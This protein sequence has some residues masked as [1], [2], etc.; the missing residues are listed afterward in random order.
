MLALNLF[1]QYYQ[2]TEL[3]LAR[4]IGSKELCMIWIVEVYLL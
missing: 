2:T 3:D 4:R 1:A